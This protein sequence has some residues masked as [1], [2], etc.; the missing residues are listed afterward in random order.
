M[1]K[2]IIIK[3]CLLLTFTALHPSIQCI[4]LW[5]YLKVLKKK[6]LAYLSLQ[7]VN[8]N[9]KFSEGIF[10]ININLD[11]LVRSIC[12]L[13]SMCV[14]RCICCFRHIISNILLSTERI[15]KS[16]RNSSSM[17]WPHTNF[18]GNLFF[19]WLARESREVFLLHTAHAW[20]RKIFK[21]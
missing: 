19:I 5:G 8:K 1:Y 12:V 6:F 13:Q 21:L 17:L 15:H 18:Q 16:S 7:P 2:I 9:G 10:L 14:L 11:L 3:K 4:K 20:R